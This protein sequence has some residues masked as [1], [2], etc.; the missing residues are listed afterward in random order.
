VEKKEEGVPTGAPA[1]VPTE[2]APLTVSVPVLDGGP[3][4]MEE[5]VAGPVMVSPI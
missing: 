2:I 3:V 5:E 1:P 4:P